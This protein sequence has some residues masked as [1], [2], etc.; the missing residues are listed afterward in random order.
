MSTFDQ[1]LQAAQ[2]QLESECDCCHGR[3]PTAPDDSHL[4]EGDWTPGALA[5][6]FKPAAPAKVKSLAELEAESLAY[7]G[8]A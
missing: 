4:Y 1:Q 7:W 6:W 5:H 3:K 8:F 2:R